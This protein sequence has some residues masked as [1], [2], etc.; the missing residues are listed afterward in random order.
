MVWCL[1]F[2]FVCLGYCFSGYF[3]LGCF[4]LRVVGWV[5]VGGLGL[6]LCVFCNAIGVCFVCDVLHFIIW[7]SGFWVGL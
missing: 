6:S 7:M 4:V 5:L 3:I 2:V 1:C